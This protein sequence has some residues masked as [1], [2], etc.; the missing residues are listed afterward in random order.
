MEDSDAA[1]ATEHKERLPVVRASRLPKFSRTAADF[2]FRSILD[3]F[4]REKMEHLYGFEA[5]ND[6]GAGAVMGNDVLERIV[7]C[8]R[9]NE[10]ASLDNLKQYVSKWSRVEELGLEIT[11]LVQRHF[12][13]PKLYTS[14]PLCPGQ[15][16]SVTGPGGAVRFAG[17]SVKQIICGACG[18]SGHTSMYLCFTLTNTH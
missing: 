3:N 2:K 18:Q 9:C 8:A 12:P 5:L 13:S 4:R 7:D 16:D 1:E 15:S 11:A 14:T 17:R 6:L 10:I